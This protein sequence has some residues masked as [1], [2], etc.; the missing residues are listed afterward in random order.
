MDN[1]DA[2]G[3][4]EDCLMRG[5]WGSKIIRKMIKMIQARADPRTR[6][7]RKFMKNRNIFLFSSRCSQTFVNHRALANIVD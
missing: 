7:C 4:E 1:G 2:E 6:P 5:G 3:G